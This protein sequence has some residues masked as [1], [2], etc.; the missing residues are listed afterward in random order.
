MAPQQSDPLP[1]HSPAQRTGGELRYGMTAPSAARA[2]GA[3]H[4]ALTSEV[5]IG[6][7]ASAK[8]ACRVH[9]TLPNGS[10]L[11]CGRNDRRRK[12]V[13][14]QKKKL[15]GEATQFFPS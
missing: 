5:A 2:V 4:S 10:R 3:D 11:S 1:D 6:A 12:A 8:G 14:P 9:D 15:A 13:E 7:L